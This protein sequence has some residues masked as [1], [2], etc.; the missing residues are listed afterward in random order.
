[1]PNADI[2]AFQKQA[3]YMTLHIATITKNH[4]VCVSDRLISSSSGHV[5]ELANDRYKHL[6]LITDDGSAVI[7]FAGI[8][9]TINS[10][11]ELENST[12]NWLTQALNEASGQ[13]K[14]TI[15]EHLNKLKDSA[16]EFLKNFKT[17][18]DQ[19]LS[20]FAVGQRKSKQF[21]SVIHNYLDKRLDDSGNIKQDFEMFFEN[22]DKSTSRKGYTTIY[23]GSGKRSAEKQEDLIKQ[24]KICAKKNVPKNI[25][26]TSVQVIKR[27]APM[28]RGSVGTNCSG[29]RIS[30]HDPGIE[31]YDHRENVT[32]DSV[33][34]NVVVSQSSGP[35]GASFSISDV[36]Y[37]KDSNP[38][39]PAVLKYLKPPANTSS[40]EHQLKFWYRISETIHIF[41]N[42]QASKLGVKPN[43]QASSKFSTWRYEKYDPVVRAI[44]LKIFE[45]ESELKAS[46][47][48]GYND[49]IFATL[50]E[51]QRSSDFWD[52]YIDLRD[53][54]EF[55]A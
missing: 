31:A 45:V 46:N 28:S 2:T 54:E 30:I 55:S 1:V 43:K 15:I 49:S 24:L 52:R 19:R 13:N 22:V 34:P 10:E 4:I 51:E 42:Q 20:I 48:N 14:Y 5:I 36:T 25:F 17:E 8:A 33:M 3:F 44:N 38:K 18:H 41:N 53:I 7:S 11:G 29:V 37:V 32:R 35:F 50:R 9:G 40:L 39:P 12:L 47:P 26:D 21:I 16:P 6:V 23:L 27:V